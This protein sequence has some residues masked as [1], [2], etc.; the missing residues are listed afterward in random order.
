MVQEKL[1]QL[2]LAEHLPFLALVEQR[3]KAAGDLQILRA[4][5][6]Y[7]AMVSSPTL[8]RPPESAPKPSTKEL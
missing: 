1:Q 5:K 3:A 4:I 8:T 2:P 7:R 6:D